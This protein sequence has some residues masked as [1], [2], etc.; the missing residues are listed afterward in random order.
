M[1]GENLYDI[2]GVTSSVTQEELKKVYRKLA[3]KNHP[4]KGGSEEKFK[5]IS[6]A[7]AT[8]SDPEKRREYD[9]SLRYGSRPRHQQAHDFHGFHD[10]FDA[11]FRQGGRPAR[12]PVSQPKPKQDKDIKFNL[13][14][15][16]EQIKRGAKQ[17]INFNRVVKCEPCDGKGGEGRKRCMTCG[18]TGVE[19]QRQGPMVAQFP[20]RV[21][22]GVGIEFAK[23]C[24]H[25]RGAGAVKVP[26]SVVV[27]I[28]ESK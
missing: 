9:M 1:S 28:K 25:C 2:L 12:P 19:T 22:H 18:G 7:Y 24:G 14:I 6:S 5:L 10:I 8:L 17:R 21:C 3:L 16:L 4:D 27:E 26:Q 11:F 20:C 13:G 23:V 15:N